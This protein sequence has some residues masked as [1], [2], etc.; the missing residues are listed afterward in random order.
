M[1]E[2]NDFKQAYSII[3]KKLLSD[4]PI[5]YELRKYNFNL[6]AHKYATKEEY[7]LYHA[8][9]R[10][11]YITKTG[12]EERFQKM[13]NE[14]DKYIASDPYDRCESYSSYA[15][16]YYDNYCTYEEKIQ[17]EHVR[18]L[19]REAKKIVFN[20]LR[21]ICMANTTEEFDQ[22][23]S[24]YDDKYIYKARY[25]V[26][27]YCSSLNLSQTEEENLK[28]ILNDKITKYQEFVKAKKEQEKQQQRQESNRKKLPQSE[29]LVKS[30]I[31]QKKSKRIFCRNNNIDLDSLEDAIQVV[32]EENQELYEQYTSAVA[33]NQ[34]HNFRILIEML[35]Y[36][37][38]AIQ[39]GIKE[40]DNATR[41]FEIFDYYALTN[42]SLESMESISKN[43]SATDARVLRAFAAKYKNGRKV[44]IKDELES[45]FIIK[46]HTVTEEEKLEV[47]DYLKKHN[48]PMTTIVY[49]QAVRRHINGK[50]YQTDDE[51]SK[52]LDIKMD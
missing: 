13:K 27:N 12:S 26:N 30:F 36:I 45:T 22:I 51:K 34:K 15:H 18:D 37:A 35:K 4:E 14:F 9:R 11:K 29:L 2:R 52:V 50:L 28:N 46:N 38:N 5:H 49:S 24:K 33:K 19:K 47:F 21:D 39:N 7:D 43:L 25:N 10:K 6:A 17:Y 3:I 44:N 48:M 8:L 23:S 40:E 16:R 1:T 41:P 42:L 32:S 20:F 31:A